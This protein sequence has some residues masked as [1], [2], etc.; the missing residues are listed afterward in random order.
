MNESLYSEMDVDSI[1]LCS[2]LNI[3]IYEIINTP[4]IDQNNEITKASMEIINKGQ[5]LLQQLG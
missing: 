4:L 3:L 5:V 2:E 1:N